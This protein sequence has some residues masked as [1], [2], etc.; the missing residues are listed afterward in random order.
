MSLCILAGGKAMTLAVTAFTLAWTHSVEKTAWEEDWR[1]TEAGLQLVEA[2]VKGSGAGME[3]PEGATLSNGWWQWTPTL[4]AQS[5]L[6]LAASG[7]TASGWS[8]CAD[9]QCLSLGAQAQE[10]VAVEACER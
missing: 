10:P 5:K 7:A 4:P 3:P 8:L 1:I 9:G 2:R 6:L